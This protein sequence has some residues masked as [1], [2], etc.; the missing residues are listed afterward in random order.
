V[1]SAA[2]PLTLPHRTGENPP[3]T[4]LAAVADKS[5]T[6]QARSGIS[7]IRRSDGDDVAILA[8]VTV[9]L[10]ALLANCRTQNHPRALKTG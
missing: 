1:D 6:K 10:G 7:Q 5:L 8:T 3:V 9:L 2:I 4:P